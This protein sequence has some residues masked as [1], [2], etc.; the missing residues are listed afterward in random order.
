M[1]GGCMG[2]APAAMPPAGGKAPEKVPA[3]KRET[4]TMAPAP[5]TVVVSLPAEAKLTVDGTPTVSTSAL[6]RFVSP[7]LEQ[8]QE[9]YYEFK[10][11]IVRDGKAVTVSRK[12]AVRAGEETQV[13]IEAP[14][15]S[16]AAK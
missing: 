12:V 13:A 6:R 4:K 10:A 2:G 1:G 8:G 3:P 11:E 9:Y 5:A 14:L 16:V 15:A 7:A